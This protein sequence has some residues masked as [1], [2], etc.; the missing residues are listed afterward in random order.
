[1]QHLDLTWDH[2]KRRSDHDLIPK[3]V[4]AANLS[5]ATRADIKA[6]AIGY[7]QAVRKEARP[8]LMEAF[9]SEY[10]LSSD[11]GVALMCLAEAILRIPDARTIDALIDDKIA[12]AN[13]SEH[14]NQSGSAL[15]NSST[16]GLLLTQQVLGS[17]GE[18]AAEVL[19][20]MVRRMGTPAIRTAVKAV[21]RQM[22]RQFVLAETIDA[23]L[24][25][26]MR[27][28][29]RGV[30]YS[31]DMLGEAA[32][33]AADA[34][35]F[36][37][38]YQNAINT[39][40]R[41]PMLGGIKDNPG[42][43]IKLS[44]LHPRYEVAQSER[45]LA[46]LVP[47]VRDLA[48]R[49]AQANMGM[50][51][52]A[53]EADRL[54]LSM[55]VIREVLADPSLRGWDGFGIVVQAY[56]RRAGEIIDGLYQ[57]SKD[58]D[59]RLMVRLVKGAYWDSEIK[60]AQVDGLSGYPVL[61]HKSAS[62]VSF[63]SL[64]NRLLG[65]T[66]YLY[67]QFGTHNAHSIAAILEMAKGLDPQSFEFQRLHGMGET[68]YRHLAR[69]EGI[70]CRVYAPVGPHRELLA[71]LVRRLL[72]NGA[73][74]SFV[75][76]L[77]DETIAAEDLV[78]CPFER[79]E[80]HLRLNASPILLP[81]DLFRPERSNARGW[82]LADLNEL[83]AIQAQ[84]HE[85]K[86]LRIEPR[87]A[88]SVAVMPVEDRAT[89]PIH[90]PAT[91]AV[92]GEVRTTTA[93]EV[94]AA[95]DAAQMWNS[96][97]EER[98][99][100]LNKIADLY[101]QNHAAAFSLLIAEAGKTLPDAVAELRE[102]IDFL[103]YYAAQVKNLTD[104]SKPRGTYVCI[105][106]WNFPLAIFTGQI[107]AALAAGNAVI[108]KPAETTAAIAD[109]ATELMHQ[110][111]VP[112]TAL[113]LLPGDGL[114]VG[115]QL[116]RDRRVH[117]VAFTGSTATARKI[118]SEMAMACAPGTPLIAETG[119][120]NAMVVDSTA[121]PEQAIQGILTSAFQ[122]AGQR[123]SALRCL[124]VQED[125]AEALIE[126]LVGAID[127]LSM[128]DPSDISTDVGPIITQE[129]AA[130]IEDYC[131]QAKVAGTLL[132]R[133]SGSRPSRGNFVAPALI[134]VE[135]IEALRREVF[136]PVLHVATYKANELEAVLDAIN[137]TGYGLTFGIY[138]RINKRI[139]TAF[140]RVRAGN[141]YANR[142]QIGAIVGSQPFG[143]EGLSGTGPK[144]GGP[145][146]LPR[147]R[148]TAAPVR[149]AAWPEPA[150]R[151]ALAAE[152]AA[153]ASEPADHPLRK[154]LPGPTGESNEL[155]LFPRAPLLCAGP[156]EK[157]AQ[158][159]KRYVE[160]LGGRAVMTGGRFAAQD[161]KHLPAIGGLLWWG[162]E[163]QGRAYAQFLAS[164][165]GP[166]IPLITELPDAAFVM[167]ERHLCVDTTAAGGNASLLVS[168]SQ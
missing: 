154:T 25:Q 2:N 4:E 107:A 88:P 11:E 147:F 3:L 71:Y 23:A 29:K 86:R 104:G 163:V 124:Y 114:A 15:V 156:G 24:D 63:I 32:L 58:L 50:N 152:I 117:G 122:S 1:M 17:S 133:Y 54:G 126:Q 159:Q 134:R 12:G 42:I 52:D 144:A 68:L 103:R 157:A 128:G 64:A 165:P 148:Q 166:I 100:K 129:A 26:A 6:R 164:L 27:K 10:G 150:D 89:T 40:A 44:A 98:A 30:T 48:H 72:E 96:A 31:Y 61:T 99:A 92:L 90:N 80:R 13:W 91:G 45:V 131:Q 106:P 149:D 36:Q 97:A 135:G 160:Q 153:V 81:S 14:L 34:L 35:R 123:C 158:A 55:A 53:E 137:A 49:A 60:Q 141:I 112:Q 41:T 69:S 142:N 51:I 120:L 79:L 33:T 39:I 116:T 7:V 87:L 38:Q 125:V 115:T 82:D 78:A 119:G 151:S 75:N 108:A 95:L 5:D 59:Q 77:A 73:N 130:A 132:H 140:A 70:R 101:E 113:Q 143:G 102:A 105:S 20:A 121:L 127:Q 136:G 110:G 76:Q 94:D 65:M 37:N 18:G 19:Q 93:T 155:A 22:G 109:W 8:G 168:A 138:T 118:Q 43:S 47:R 162:D 67:P 21:I 57:L 62:D 111:G 56:S 139:E 46:E 161:L 66:D 74:S 16:I 167:S 146:Y 84:L 9:L 85:P 145:N 83:D 28:E